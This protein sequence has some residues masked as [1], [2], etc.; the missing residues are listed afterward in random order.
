MAA[1]RP[2]ILLIMSDEHDAAV[3]GCYGDQV[4]DT[5]HLD[6]LAARG[7]A[8]DACYCNS[9]LCVPSRQSFT[10][11]KYVSRIDAWSNNC[12]IPADAPSLPRLLN[13]AGYQSYLCG[14]Q[15]YPPERRYGFTEISDGR[16]NKNSAPGGS[17]RRAADD[18]TIGARSWEQR[19]S[20]F[21][22]GE[23]FVL[24]ND[25][26]VTET[27]SAFLAERQADEAPFFLFAGYLA[28]HFPL[29]VPDELLGKYRGRV[30]DPVIPSG[31][32][33]HLPRNYQHLRRGFGVTE[34]DDETV[35][36]G[37]E[38]YWALTEWFDAEVGELLGALRNSAVADDTVVIYCSDH[39]ENKG[40]HGLWW[41]NCMFDHGVRVP[42][43]V[44]WPA[45][46][47]GGQRRSQACSLLDLVQTLAAIGE[48]E[49]P[50]DWDGDSLLPWLDDHAYAW[51]DLAVSEYYGHN[52]CS[53]FAM[54]RRGDWKYVYHTR[55][56]ADHG[57]EREL[58][59]MRKDPEEFHTLAGDPAQA[60]RIA[61]LHRQL[62]AELG[63]EPDEAER[64]CQAQTEAL[65]H[66][67]EAETAR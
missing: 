1:R 39:G 53:G 20:E 35:R 26:H 55:P 47:A 42:L 44:S 57:P 24:D 16:Q 2:N 29:L 27:A 13:A 19:S 15:H 59:D 46:W 4:V 8:F 5:P 18:Q 9:P 48:A 60:E 50:E 33:E 3:T 49:T 67:R 62:V 40:D 12:A 65:R 43:I 64:R 52:I 38:C 32:L 41:K 34:A 25:R 7:V 51:K 37:R 22:P 45:R 63:D 66:E 31:L 17:P 6:G 14:K 56:D 28:P 21:G 30:P 36:L 11:G 10:A 61:D 58:Y 54:L 23:S